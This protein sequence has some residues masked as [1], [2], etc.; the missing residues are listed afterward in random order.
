[1]DRFTEAMGQEDEDVENLEAGLAG[2]VFNGWS[3]EDIIAGV[4][5]MVRDARA[6]HHSVL[7]QVAQRSGNNA[8]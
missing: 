8:K 3:D 7:K 1:M 4:M 6:H 2:L 5:E